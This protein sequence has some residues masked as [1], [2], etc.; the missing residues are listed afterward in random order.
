MVMAATCAATPQA[1]NY[2]AQSG[3]ADRH[4]KREQKCEMV[5]TDDRVTDA[6]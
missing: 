6:G 3:S 1:R 4:T 5:R 2:E